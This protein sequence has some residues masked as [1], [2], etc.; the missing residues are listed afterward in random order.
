MAYINGGAMTVIYIPVQGG[1][2][3]DD[4]L[5]ST[6]DKAPKSEDLSYSYTIQRFK[7]LGLTQEESEAL[8]KG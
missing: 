8:T 6:T 3:E 7:S 4:P 2:K 1:G 5:H